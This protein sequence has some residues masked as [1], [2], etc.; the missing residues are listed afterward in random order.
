MLGAETPPQNLQIALTM[1]HL[2]LTSILAWTDWLA[3]TLTLISCLSLR[4]NM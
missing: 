4:S 1:G 3:L 2:A